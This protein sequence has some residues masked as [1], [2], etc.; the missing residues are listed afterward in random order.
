MPLER[1][2]T[3]TMDL[4]ECQKMS[5]SCPKTLDRAIIW[6]KTE[7]VE[8]VHGAD[9]QKEVNKAKGHREHLLEDQMKKIPH[10]SYNQLSKFRSLKQ[11]L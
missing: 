9:S 2:A 11:P 10:L 3:E 8:T 7:Q 6:A 1:G 4:R 5:R